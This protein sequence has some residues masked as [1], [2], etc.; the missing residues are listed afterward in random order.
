MAK[1]T[2]NTPSDRAPK[3]AKKP[4][5]FQQMLQVFQMT[6]RADP[7]VVW[8]MAL[9]FLVVV[10]LGVL[11]GAL[12]ENWITGLIVGILLGVLGA[13]FILSRRAER[14]A[15]S[16]IEGQPGAAGAALNTLRRGWI[17]EEQPVAMNPRTQD[18]VFRA[19][20]RPGVVLVSE[21][22]TQRVRP[23]VESE[24]KRLARVL[25]NV[26]ITVIESGREEGQTS[27][28]KVA[29]RM[30]KLKPELT[31]TEVQAINKR[32]ASLGPRLPIPKGIDPTRIRPDRRAMRG[33]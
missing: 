3:K 15:F 33:R 10:G 16:Q 17:I 2:S 28:D 21:G 13:I 9:V 27:I 32:L 14:A 18:L 22:P 25:P 1:N 23:L 11:V 31:K 24:R 30:Q 29:K 20:G 5:S 26:P 6:R 12:L 19:V 8:L 7:N 4:N